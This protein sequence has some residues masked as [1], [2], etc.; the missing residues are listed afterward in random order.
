MQ[1][2]LPNTE[3]RLQ[4]RYEQLVREHCGPAHATAAGPRA[5]PAEQVTAFASTQ[6]AWRYYHNPRLDLVQLMAPLLAAA[7]QGATE[8]CDR[9]CLVVHDWSFLDYATHTTKK[10]RI[11]VTLGKGDAVGYDLRTALLVSDRT[12]APLAPLCHDLRAADGVHSSRAAS[13]QPSDSRL[14]ELA[15][16]FDFVDAQGLARPAVHIIDREADSVG[17]YRQWHQAGYS[18]LVRADH[19]R[20]VRYDGQERSLPSVVR[21]LQRR[22]A[23][24]EVREVTFRGRRARQF[25][26]EATVILER[27]ARQHRVVQGV[28]KRKIVPGPPLTLRLVVSQVR[29]GRGRLLAEWLLFT[30]LPTEIAA[31]EVALWYYWRWQVESFFKLLKG[32]GH[33]LEHW[34]QESAAALARRLLIASMACVLV[35]QLARN[36]APEAAQLRSLLVRLSGRQMAWGVAFTEPALLAGLWVLLAMLEVLQQHSVDELR[37]LA[38]LILPDSS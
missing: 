10:D 30:N 6:A 26:A 19:D 8:V 5:V 37:A 31:A 4:R 9:F 17:H 27:P 21:C 2:P 11:R 36:P 7:H 28:K 23:F 25:V 24:H 13:V 18:F 20:L 12:G 35:W 38:A 3:P 32:A 14:D 22:G 33:E 34:Q 16:V 15:A 1:L 29:D